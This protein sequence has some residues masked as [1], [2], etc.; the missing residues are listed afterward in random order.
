[1]DHASP[2]TSAIAKSTSSG[3]GTSRQ[4]LLRRA[5]RLAGVSWSGP[6]P[7]RS[8]APPRVLIEPLAYPRHRERIRC[9][10]H[11]GTRF[12]L[13]MNANDDVTIVITCFNYGAFLAE[14]VDSAL[15][16]E[17][18][19]PRVVVVDDGSPDRQTLAA[20]ERLPPRVELVRQS[21]AGVAAARNAGLA[22]AGTPF[23]LVLD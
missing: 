15:D 4:A 18:G 9:L 22:L 23:V 2:S 1:M 13:A 20:L 17:S 5:A 21:N 12:T 19:E 7:S 11:D 8:I 6:V 14:A 3:R 16:Q 10:A